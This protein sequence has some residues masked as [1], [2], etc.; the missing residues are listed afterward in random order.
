MTDASDLAYVETQRLIADA[1]AKSATALDLD[2]PNTW[3]LASIPPEIAKL[4]SLKHLFLN[5]TKIADLSPLASLVGLELLDLRDTSVVDLSPVAKMLELKELTL[6]RTA[7]TDLSALMELTALKKLDLWGTNVSDLLP[8]A[9]ISSLTTLD[10]QGTLVSDLSPLVGLPALL[11]P[12]SSTYNNP[13]PGLHFL[14]TPACNAPRIAEIAEIEDPALR[15]RTLFDYLKPE[16][17]AVPEDSPVVPIYLVPDTGPISS[18]EDPFHGADDDLEH[19]RQDLMRKSALLVAAIGNSN[20]MAVLKGAA[21]HFQRQIDKQLVRIRVN[22]LYSAAN[23]LRVAYEADVR[24]DQLGNLNDLLPPRVAAPLKDLVETHALFFMGFPNA[25]EVQ[26][27]MLAGLTGARNLQQVALAEPIVTSLESKALVLEPEDQQALAD[28]LAGAKGQGASAEIAE[29]R[30]FA[31]LGNIFGALGRKVYREMKD[32]AKPTTVVLIQYDIIAYVLNQQ[33]F[34]GAFLK[35]M[36]GAG[37]A[38]FDVVAKFLM[39]L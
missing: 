30:L 32:N 12:G 38:W 21:E 8:L 17:P 4:T 23:S 9:G 13:S 39:R 22:L 27:T 33:T 25:A 35:S 16:P 28:D 19:L 37:A 26:Q 36:Q 31:R 24:A 20:E 34:I 11:S 7:V 10:L 18:T 2:T 3:A 14:N 5:G 1:R 15:A 29:R 6:T